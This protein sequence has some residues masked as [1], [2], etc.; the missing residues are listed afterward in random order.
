MS[1]AHENATFETEVQCPVCD[2]GTRVWGLGSRVQGLGSSREA[3]PPKGVL[4]EDNVLAPL[5]RASWYWSCQYRGARKLRGTDPRPSTLDPRPEALD[6]RP[7]TLHPR[8][9]TICPC[10]R[11]PLDTRH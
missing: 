3:H 5:R 7:S 9:S 10:R 4:V 1:R 2:R 11:Q 8:P 6:P